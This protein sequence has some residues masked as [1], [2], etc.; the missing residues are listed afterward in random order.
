MRGAGVCAS[1]FRVRR[2]K[3]G[4]KGD[5]SSRDGVPLRSN[6][7]LTRA[8]EIAT[9]K[10]VRQRRT[11]L[12]RWRTATLEHCVDARFGDRDERRS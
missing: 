10:V 3:S 11:E 1:W 9:R 7:V 5:L 2:A 4:V 12:R 8:L 6:I